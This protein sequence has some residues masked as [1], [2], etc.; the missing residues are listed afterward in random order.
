MCVLVSLVENFIINFGFFLFFCPFPS[1]TEDI[2]KTSLCDAFKGPS[3]LG[4][5]SGTIPDSALSA[6]SSYN[7]QSVGPQNARYGKQKN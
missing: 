1:S 7:E 4:M 5:E 6:S 2:Q 3:A